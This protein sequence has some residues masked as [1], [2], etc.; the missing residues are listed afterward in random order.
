MEYVRNGR[1]LTVRARKEV[2]L[3]A[4][5]VGS[6]H[7]LLLSGVGPKEH[8]KNLGVKFET[9]AC[10]ETNQKEQNRNCDSDIFLSMQVKVIA[11]LPV[12]EHLQDHLKSDMGLFSLPGPDSLAPERTNSWSEWFKYAVFGTGKEP[13]RSQRTSSQ[14]VSLPFVG[15]QQY[16]MTRVPGIK[17]GVGVEASGFR[18]SVHQP[19]D[20]LRPYLQFTTFGGLFG[21]DVE[22]YWKSADSL[23]YKHEVAVQHLTLRKII[24]Q[25]LYFGF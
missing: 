20:D 8:L 24:Y 23:N 4:G 2:I 18:R 12:G 21:A 1:L 5:S 3:S 10:S 7:I 17:A 19:K 13:D 11:D 14:F 16:T 6:P 22:N 25:K 9:I 15:T